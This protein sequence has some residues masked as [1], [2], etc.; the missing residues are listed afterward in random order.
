MNG[1]SEKSFSAADRQAQIFVFLG[2][3]FTPIFAAIALAGCALPVTVMYLNI[4][5]PPDPR[6]YA[7]GLEGMAMILGLC[8][9]ASLAFGIAAFALGAKTIRIIKTWKAQRP[10]N[11]VDAASV[12]NG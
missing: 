8:L 2:I 1:P 11:A 7:P 3:V 9:V 5:A 4:S 6:T 10:D 12:R